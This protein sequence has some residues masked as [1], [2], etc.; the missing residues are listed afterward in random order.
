M[1]GSV[2]T[3]VTVPVQGSWDPVGLRE[4]HYDHTVGRP[5]WGSPEATFMLPAFRRFVV[6]VC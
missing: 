6:N 2:Q 5:V 1:T 3:H 4:L